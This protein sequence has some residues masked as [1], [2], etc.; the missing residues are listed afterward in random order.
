M[1]QA[2]SLPHAGSV[3]PPSNPP[4]GSWLNRNRNRYTRPWILQAFTLGET[5]TPLIAVRIH[6]RASAPGGNSGYGSG[7]FGTT[8]APQGPPTLFVNDITSTLVGLAWT[9]SPGPA[10]NPL[11]SAI[12]SYTIMERICVR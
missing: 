12:V 4:N 3:L 8:T 5:D 1:L 6:D 9:P 7:I 10:Q 2:E 11:Y